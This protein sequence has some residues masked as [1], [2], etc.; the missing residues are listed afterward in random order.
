MSV[1]VQVRRIAWRGSLEA[2]GLRAAL[3]AGML[4][5]LALRTRRVA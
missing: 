4:D 1:A 2:R 3:G 5:R